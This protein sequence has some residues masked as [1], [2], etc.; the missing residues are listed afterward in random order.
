MIFIHKC[1]GKNLYFLNECNNREKTEISFFNL[2]NEGHIL[3]VKNVVFTGDLQTIDR[4][5]AMQ[6][7]VDLGGLVK[8]GVS[9][10]TNYLVVGQQDKAQVGDGGL[11][12]KE[13]KAYALKE[14]G[15]EIKI[16]RETEFLALIES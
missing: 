16:I 15:I 14:Q 10:K 8:S 5:S 11:S 1:R 3:F 6:K 4:K 2:Q 12:T 13:K 7:V 9:G